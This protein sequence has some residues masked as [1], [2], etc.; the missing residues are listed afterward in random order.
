MATQMGSA[1]PTFPKPTHGTGRKQI[2][3]VTVWDAISDL[4]SFDWNK[5]TP[6][7]TDLD[8]LVEYASEPLNEFQQSVRADGCSTVRYHT[9][10]SY[11]NGVRDR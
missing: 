2:P 11:K 3:R 6:L 8:R 4:P 1:L 9:T 5:T 7:Y 10:P